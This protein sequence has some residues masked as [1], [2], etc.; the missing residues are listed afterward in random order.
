MVIETSGTFTQN[1]SIKIPKNSSL[2][3]LTNTI[4]LSADS[5]NTYLMTNQKKIFVTIQSNEI[6]F[7]LEPK[8]IVLNDTRSM[9]C[10]SKCSKNKLWHSLML[11]NETGSG[12]AQISSIQN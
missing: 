9:S 2:N 10:G 7:D 4:T 12:L 6:R 11:I 8:C 3:G 5:K 1:M